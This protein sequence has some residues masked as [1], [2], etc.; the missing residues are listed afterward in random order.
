MTDPRDLI[1]Y[2]IAFTYGKSFVRLEYVSTP[3][4]CFQHPCSTP[5][6]LLEYA[7]AQVM[8]KKRELHT[9]VI[10]R[11]RIRDALPDVPA[12]TRPASRGAG[13]DDGGDVDDGGDDDDEE[14]NNED[15]MDDERSERRRVAREAAIK[16]ATFGDGVLNE[17][18]YRCALGVACSLTLDIQGIY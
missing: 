18:K 1:L 4:R 11:Q 2:F 14:E 12:P 15:D 6:P 7:S 13:G 8:Q 9:A 16:T 17:G 10:Q 3:W 5:A